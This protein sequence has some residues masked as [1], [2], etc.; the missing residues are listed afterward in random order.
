MC[1]GAYCT[2]QSVGSS[3]S[4][5]GRQGRLTGSPSTVATGGSTECGHLAEEGAMWWQFGTAG[6][7]LWSR[8]TASV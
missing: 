5:T 2:C 8:R 3:D 7:Q 6:D 4:W 1:V